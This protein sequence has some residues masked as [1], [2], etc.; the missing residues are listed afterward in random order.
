MQVSTS[1]TQLGLGSELVD[2]YRDASSV[3]YGH[4]LTD[5]LPRTNDQLPYCTN[6]AS[7][8]SKSFTPQRLKHLQSLDDEH[9]KFLY[10]PSVPVIFP[11]VHK[12]FH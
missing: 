5:W 3:P 10:S 12:I 2:W 9:T 8:P 1:S 6:T 4:L 11:Q 7:I